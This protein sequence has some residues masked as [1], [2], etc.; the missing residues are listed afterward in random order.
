MHKL[1]KNL[2][3]ENGAVIVEATIVFPII[4]FVLF[5]LI[6]FGSARYEKAKVDSYVMQSAILGAQC[7]K[8]PYQYD[9]YKTGSVPTKYTNCEPY[10]YFIGGMDDVENKI[11]ADVVKYINDTSSTF[12]VGMNPKL[13]TSQDKI[14]KFNNYLIYST[15]SVEVNYEVKFPIKFFGSNEPTILEW[16]S[17]AEVSV[18]DAPEFIRNIDMVQDLFEGTAAGEKIKSAFKK[19]NS[20]IGKF[21]K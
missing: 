11:S 9:M 17:R 19:I 14:A 6:F 15:F 8:D 12:F 3:N 20:F 10:R 2:K 21:S 1:F 13:K 5:F 7:S 16:N 18:N 4:F